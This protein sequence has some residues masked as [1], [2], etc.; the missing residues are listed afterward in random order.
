M[1]QMIMEICY[2]NSYV[3]FER[4]FMFHINIEST[5]QEILIENKGSKFVELLKKLKKDI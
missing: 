4:Y 5:K 3:N 2:A 1:F